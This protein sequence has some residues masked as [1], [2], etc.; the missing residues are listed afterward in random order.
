MISR[1]HVYFAV[2]DPTRGREQGGRRPVLVV[3]VDAINRRP[4]VVTV[5]VGTDA[6]KIDRDY[7]TNVRVTAE[8]SGLPKDTVF[9]GFQMRSLDP[10]RFGA[11][12]G[13]LP[14]S[15]MSEVDRALRVV[16]GL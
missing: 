15:R 11:P 5:V 9:L 16:L 4:L 14:G 10:S 2:L 1:G 8:E 13:V 12:C 3:S 7:P 6:A